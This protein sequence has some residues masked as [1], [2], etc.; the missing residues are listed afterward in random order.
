MH[1]TTDD[2]PGFMIGLNSILRDDVRV[3][4]TSCWRQWLPLKHAARSCCQAE[5]LHTYQLAISVEFNR[6]RTRLTAIV[7]NLSQGYKVALNDMRSQRQQGGIGGIRANLQ[8]G[9]RERHGN[10]LV[11][12]QDMP[13]SHDQDTRISMTC[14]ERVR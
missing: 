4:K 8:V 14:R 10:H 6:E 9:D 1:R 2:S 13:I 3:Q 12:R 5:G 7:G 11:G